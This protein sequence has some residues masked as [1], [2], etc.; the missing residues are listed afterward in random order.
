MRSV[1]ADQ[2]RR[3]PASTPHQVFDTIVSDIA[4][5]IMTRAPLP[6][7]VGRAAAC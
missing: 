1:I 6:A 7:M 5:C 3:W 2:G 4:Q